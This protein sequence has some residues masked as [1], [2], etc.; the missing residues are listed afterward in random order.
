M[1]ARSALAAV[2][3]LGVL[4]PVAPA[5]AAAPAP[6][7]RADVSAEDREY[8]NRTHQNN[9]F[10]IFTGDLTG[11]GKCLAVRELGPRFAAHHTDLDAELVGVAARE[12][13][14]LYSVPEPGQLARIADLAVRSGADFDAA[15]LREQIA[16]HLEAIALAD[17]ETRH[18]WSAEVKALAA[19]SA[20]VLHHHFEEVVSAL[21]ACTPG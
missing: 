1:K 6:P 7:V 13:V 21:N 20:P 2:A 19:R 4:L 17:V 10:E 9:L 18:G 3:V 12:G 15:W 14:T 16:A 5:A 11:R 8:L